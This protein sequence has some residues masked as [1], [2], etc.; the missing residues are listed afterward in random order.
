MAS[1]VYIVKPG[2]SPQKIAQKYGMTW[3][4]LYNHPVNMSLKV[5]RLNPNIILPGDIVVIPSQTSIHQPNKIKE[6]V[7]RYLLVA[8]DGTGSKKWAKNDASNSHIMKFCN[9]F[10]LGPKRYFHGPGNTGSDTGGIIN[11]ALIW[12]LREL[13]GFAGGNTAS[14]GLK[15]GEACVAPDEKLK[16]CM[17]GHS[18]GGLI[19]INLARELSRYG[20][21]VHFMGLYDAVDRA[22]GYDGA[23]VTNVHHTFH[24]L[25]DPRLRSRTSFRNTGREFHANYEEHVFSTSHG[26]TG[27]DPNFNNTWNPTDDESCAPS[28]TQRELNENR[29]FMHLSDAD[30]MAL[31]KN[32]S[33][34]VGE[35]MRYKANSVGIRIGPQPG[36]PIN[37]NSRKFA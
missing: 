2:D 11:T 37:M 6:E 32:E 23:M 30:R 21:S 18:R 25:R 17:V 5:K 34:R 7:T 33:V 8:V 28:E 19:T 10:S 1:E 15:G 13:N 31:C 12:I 29:K 22:I 16:I 9:D 36:I 27:G 3:E 35:W 14:S 24:A 26:G 20:F 4:Y